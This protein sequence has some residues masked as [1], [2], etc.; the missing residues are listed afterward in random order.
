MR[1]IFEKI[2]T[3]SPTHFHSI[4]VHLESGCI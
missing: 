1:G 3:S 4:K 2:L